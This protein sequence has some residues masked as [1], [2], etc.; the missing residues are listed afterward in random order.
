[1]QGFFSIKATPMGANLV[2][3]EELEEGIIQALI[4]DAK[5]WVYEQFEAIR[6]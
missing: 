5:D 3:L 2:L 6:K 4:D 1:M